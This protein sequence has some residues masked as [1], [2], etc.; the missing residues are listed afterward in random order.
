LLFDHLIRAREHVGRNHQAD[1][2]RCLEIDHKFKLGRLLHRQVGRLR[3]LQ[4]PIHEI[5]DPL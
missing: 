1:L 2:L 5:C 3:S 4:N